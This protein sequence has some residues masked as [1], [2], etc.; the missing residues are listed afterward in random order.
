MSLTIDT[1]PQSNER[2][3]RT[4]PSEKELTRA[5]R[6]AP[7]RR[8]DIG[9]SRVAYWRFGEGPDVVFVHGW[10]LDAAT[11][12]RIVPKLAQSYTCHLFDLPGVGQT[13]SDGDAPLDL[14]SHG[15]SVRRLV[16]ALGLDRYAFLA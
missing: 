3:L 13:E 7:H 8:I 2:N 11:F 4:L 1:V 5:F 6:G 16:D 10:P 14:V 9:H 12:R 15:A